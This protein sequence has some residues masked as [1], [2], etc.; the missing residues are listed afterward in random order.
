MQQ[1]TRRVCITL[2]PALLLGAAVV[3]APSTGVVSASAA[4]PPIAF[5]VPRVADPIRSDTLETTPPSPSPDVSP[6][7]STLPNTSGTGAA[8]TLAWPA[9]LLVLLVASALTVVEAGRTRSRRR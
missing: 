4:L 5:G 1:L 2:V 8:V 7:P 6:L 3:L 9:V